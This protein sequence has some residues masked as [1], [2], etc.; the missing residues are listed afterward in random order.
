MAETNNPYS[1]Q[2]IGRNEP[3]PCGSG[4]K[5]KRCHG[6]TSEGVRSAPRSQSSMANGLGA[7]AMP[8]GFDPSQIDPAKM[9]Q[10]AQAMQRLP[11]G[12]MQKIQSLMQRAMAGKDVSKE[13]EMLEKMLPAGLKE[14]MESF[15]P[16]QVQ[17]PA[18]SIEEPESEEQSNMSVEEAK[19]VIEEAVAQ[20]EVSREQADELLKA[21][22]LK[23]EMESTPKESKLG[24]FWKGLR[25]K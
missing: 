8:G 5:Y 4:K 25:G 23:T 10:L 24:K 9:A 11:R 20:G 17:N 18:E 19:K 16:A 22:G 1:D 7:G 14:M 6:K 12:Q 3:C 15:V 21:Q 2:S 13:A